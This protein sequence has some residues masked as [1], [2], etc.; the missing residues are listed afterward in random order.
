[1]LSEGVKQ[2]YICARD[3]FVFQAY[4]AGYSDLIRKYHIDGVPSA[5][6]YYFVPFFSTLR[7]LLFVVGAPLLD[8][9]NVKYMYAKLEW[10]NSAYLMTSISSMSS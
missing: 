2:K 6:Q 9:L 4:G 10:K 7:Y 3:F 8:T 1:M 5:I